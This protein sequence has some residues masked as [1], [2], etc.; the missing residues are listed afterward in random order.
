MDLR[1]MVLTDLFS[2]HFDLAL[3]CFDGTLYFS[4]FAVEFIL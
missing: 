3:H 2:S 4:R 1:V